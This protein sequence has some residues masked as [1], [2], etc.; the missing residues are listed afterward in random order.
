MTARKAHHISLGCT[1]QILLGLQTGLV[2]LSRTWRIK[3][4]KIDLMWH[5]IHY[6]C[7]AF[8]L[9]FNLHFPSI[10]N[11]HFDPHHIQKQNHK[12]KFSDPPDEIS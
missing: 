8:V 4:I 7:E 1:D 12:W 2:A 5:L 3:G 10:I 9:F 6:F 11:P